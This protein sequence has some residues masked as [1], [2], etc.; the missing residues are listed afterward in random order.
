MHQLGAYCVVPPLP[1]VTRTVMIES[2]AAM[3]V[4]QLPYSVLDS[5]ATAVVGL[6]AELAVVFA[7]PAAEALL[8]VSQ[9]T[10]AGSGVVP[11]AAPCTSVRAPYPLGDSGTPRFDR[12]RFVD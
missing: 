7:N 8:D 10:S 11:A 9:K 3:S 6:D 2:V 12:T 1:P 5:L 4:T